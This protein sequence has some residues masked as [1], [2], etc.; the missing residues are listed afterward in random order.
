MSDKDF[1]ESLETSVVNDI[2]KIIYK[3]D[4]N[5]LIR[6]ISISSEDIFNQNYNYFQEGTRREVILSGFSFIL[7]LLSQNKTKYNVKC[8]TNC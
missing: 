2:K 6:F 1:L 4:K 5:Q 7:F 3:Y 8:Q